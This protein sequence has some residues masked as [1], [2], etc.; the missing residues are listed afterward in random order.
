MSYNV[1]QVQT[2]KTTCHVLILPFHQPRECNK[3]IP[4]LRKPVSRATISLSFL[5]LNPSGP[6]PT[7]SRTPG[8]NG[9]I[10]TSAVLR[11]FSNTAFDEGHLMSICIDRFLRQRMSKLDCPGLSIRTTSAPK[12]ARS[13]PVAQKRKGEEIG[14]RPASSSINL[15]RNGNYQLL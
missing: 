7:L 5:F 6:S 14:A 10:K 11:S 2:L 12:S 13:I 3:I 9:S 15:A 4:S 1:R 8:R